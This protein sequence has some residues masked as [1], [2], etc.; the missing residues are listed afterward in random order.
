[1]ANLEIK[2]LSI[3]FG[4][5]RALNDVTL[6]VPQ[7]SFIGLMGPNG[8]GKTTIINC[9]SRIYDPTAGQITFNGVDLLSLNANEVMQSGI[10]RTFQDL[11][12]FERIS[13]MNIIDY[14]RLGNF[15]PNANSM[16]K[17][18]FAT[19][20]AREHEQ[21]LKSSAR[22]I[23]EFFREMREQLEDDEQSRGFPFLHGRE[24]FPDLIDVEFEKVGSLSFA[25]RRRLDLARALVSHPQLLLLDE[26]AQGM[27]PSEVEN[28]GK[29]LKLIQKEFK[30]SALIVEHNVI[31]LSKISDQLIALNLG[32]KIAEGAP[33]EVL[34]NEKV[35]EVYL[36]AG[37]Q[38]KG[39][40]PS[41]ATQEPATQTDALL[42]SNDQSPLLECKSIDL[43][44]GFTQ[45]LFSVSIKVYPKEIVTILGTNGS[46]KSTLLRALSGVEK[47]K[48]GQIF[49]NNEKVPLGW[50]EILVERGM[51]YVPQGHVIFPELSVIENLK[52]GSSA[53]KVRTNAAF[54]ERMELTLEYFPAL[55]KSLK[56][57]AA[58]LSGGMQQ[59]L[60][61]CQALMGMPK[62][63]LLDEPTLGLAPS[64]ADELFQ[65]IKNITVK[66]GCAVLLVEQSVR[67]ACD[68]SDYI[69]MMSSGVLVGEGSKSIFKNDDSTIKKHLGFY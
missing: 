67:R 64:L 17:S 21:K 36:G 13:E 27:P 4:G 8:A 33:A 14:L 52:I 2:N 47:P 53:L 3:S 9:I 66:E 6:S 11:N 15:N 65:I 69:Y 12:F 7:G 61:I 63:L 23:L 62:I 25:W 50:P 30:I 34:K 59:M 29:M 32:T 35:I 49:F 10:A 40:D 24:G 41:V 37:S 16:V 68:I 19:R 56:A 22:R 5:I 20:Y 45:A 51:Q 55:K 58:S 39:T 26:P 28:L 43:Y 60:A 48:F 38:E 1:M 54:K 18:G 46:G 31:T 44:Y 57:Q 42:R